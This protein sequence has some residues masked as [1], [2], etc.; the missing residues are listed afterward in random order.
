[1]KALMDRISDLWIDVVD[2]CHKYFGHH[3]DGFL[4]H[5]DWGA[6][7]GPFFHERVVREMLV[8][9][10]RRVTDHIHELGYTCDLHSC[11]NIDRLVPCIIEAGWDGWD[12]MAI[13]DYHT[14]FA[15]YGDKLMMSVPASDVPADADPA[16]L[17]EWADKFAAEYAV[18]DKPV[19]LSHYDRPGVDFEMELYKQSR[20]KYSEA[21]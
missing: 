6:Q 17:K 3:F 9:Y 8:P 20:I 18:K 4:F 16:A 14:L 2:H 21:V 7:D 10:M 15:E 12:G 11:G 19:Y 1:V 13:N 5:D